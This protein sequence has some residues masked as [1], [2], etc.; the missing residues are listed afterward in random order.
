MLTLRQRANTISV[1]AAAPTHFLNNLDTDS[2]GRGSFSFSGL[3]TAQVVN[4]TVVNGT[5]YDFADFLLGLPE[6]SSIRYGDTS[7]YYRSNWL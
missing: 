4:G 1:S 3:S 7:T 5:G 6:T 2:N